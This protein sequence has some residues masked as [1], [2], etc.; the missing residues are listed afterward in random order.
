MTLYQ[1]PR[2]KRSGKRGYYS[3]RKRG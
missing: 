3:R 1:Y 2:E